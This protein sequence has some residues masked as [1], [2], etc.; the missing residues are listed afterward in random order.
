MSTAETSCIEQLLTPPLPRVSCVCVKDQNSQ[1]LTS[2]IIS[3]AKEQCGTTA[4]ADV[5]SAL[6]VFAYYCSAGKGLVSL[7]FLEHYFLLH[8]FCEWFTSWLVLAANY[9]QDTVSTP[10]YLPSR[11]C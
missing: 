4:S 9:S 3:Q 7:N 8:L 1:A 6:G 2:A 11:Q 10:S 5:S